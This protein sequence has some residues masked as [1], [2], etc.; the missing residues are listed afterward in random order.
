MLVRFALGRSTGRGRST[1]LGWSRSWVGEIK[2]SANFTA[3]AGGDFAGA[4]FT[5][6]KVVFYESFSRV[7]SSNI[8]LSLENRSDHF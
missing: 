6:W 8:T 5:V 1:G 3:L 7:L 4:T 2:V